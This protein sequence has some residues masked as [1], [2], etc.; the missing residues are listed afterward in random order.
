MKLS[1][2]YYTI[3][4]LVIVLL[5]IIA[6]WAALFYAF[7][8]DEV[9]DNVDDGLKNR[10]IQLIKAVYQDEKLLNN[11]DFAFNEFKIMP[12]SPSEYD[13][14]NKLYNRTYYMEY[15]DDDEPYRVLE[16]GF[17]DQFGKHRKL[18]IRTSTVEEDDLIYDLTIALIVLYLFLVI[19][20]LFVNGFLL[21]KAWKPFYAILNKLRNYQFG[22]KIHEKPQEYS[23]KEFEQL[24]GEIDEMIRRNEFVFYQQ[25]KFIENA[26]H[27]LQ[28]PLAIII[29]KIDLSIQKESL[30]EDH[31]NFLIEIKNNLARMVSLNK[32]LLM[33]S[34]IENNQFNK[35][36]WVNFNTFIKEMVE[37][38]EDFIRHK[39][40]EITISGNQEFEA[41]FSPDLADILISNLLKNAIKYNLS[42]G[43]INIRIYKSQIV[44]ENTGVNIPL[45]KNQIFNRFYKQNT[46]HNSTGLGLSIV[47]TIIKQ[48]PGW[49]IAYEF[50]NGLHCFS[51]TK[52]L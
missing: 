23:I 5:L 37:N 33:L 10:K 30:E 7:I 21:N 27:E 9:Y 50:K 32:S 44:F 47:T 41:S 28:T 6:V 3:K 31:L 46:D 43:K 8:L 11:V 16:T 19:S 20:I 42:N 40:I 49:D 4:Y 29:N 51:L 22:E 12:V 14:R 36:E 52:D 45:D 48:Y 18:I 38:Y 1:L 15:D 26:S 24:N 34:K 39:E 35:T 17:I 2:K 25:K 13:G